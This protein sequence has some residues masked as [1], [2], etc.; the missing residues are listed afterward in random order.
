MK[1]ELFSFDQICLIS[2][3]IGNFLFS[4]SMKSEIFH[5]VRFK[6]ENFLFVQFPNSG[7]QGA[8]LHFD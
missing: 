4:E 5:L 1:S 6:I 8:S 7:F 2:P 3:R